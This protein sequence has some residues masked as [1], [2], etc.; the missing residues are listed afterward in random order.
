MEKT[1]IGISAGFFAAATYLL[2]LFGGYVVIA[3]VAG[4]V[5]LKEDSAWLKKQCIRAVVLMLLF[6]L[7]NGVLGLI[8]DFFSIISNIIS[9]ITNSYVSFGIVDRIHS[10]FYYLLNIGKVV[11]FVLLAL[12]ALKQA[13]GKLPV[14][15]DL[16][17]K[18]LDE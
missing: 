16:I 4:Y 7:V 13:E 3:L 8:P 10:I 15:D 6:S 9:T 1:K 18:Y 17:G 2:G 11:L 5:F 14:I 12:G